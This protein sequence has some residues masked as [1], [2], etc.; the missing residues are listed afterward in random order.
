MKS[1]LYAPTPLPRL[2]YIADYVL[3][4]L[5][6]LEVIVTASEAEY[7]SFDGIRIN[8]SPTALV[9]REVHI[10]PQ[11]LLSETGV[12]EQPLG[13]FFTHGSPAIMGVLPGYDLPFD[14]LAA[15]FFVLTRYEEYLPYAPDDHGRFPAHQAW[16]WRSGCLAQPIVWQWA[17]ALAQA[18]QQ[19][20]PA[21]T[22]RPPGYGWLPTYDV[23]IPWA[24]LHRGLRGWARA[25]LDL[26]QGN[27]TQVRQRLAVHLG[28]AADPYYTF[29]ALE[30][31]HRDTHTRPRI[32]WLLADASRQDVNPPHQLPAYR[33][34]VQA[35]SAWS[36]FGI[37]PGYYAYLDAA[38][39]R[40]HKGRLEA[41]LDAPVT[42]SRQHFLRMHLPTT[43]RALLDAGIRHDYTMGFAEAAGYRAGATEPFRWYDLAT[44]QLTD[45]WVHPF[46]AMDVTLQQYMALPPA[47]AADQ[48]ATFQTYCR[49]QGLAFSTLW[50][51]SSF[52]DTHG[53]AGWWP[54]YRG[55][56]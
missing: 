11:G 33:Q 8:Y 2:A 9:E 34:L 42:H 37:H 13:T 43:Y 44:E 32:F 21:W 46:V 4:T 38:A 41:I 51:N 56:F 22:H 55:L 47:D 35:A 7:R 23:D 24:Y 1:T 6:G 25:G 12:R 10:C 53:W 54:V 40:Q 49:Q 52:S 19:H 15:S 16:A 39:I 45:L 17:L 3:G 18:I 14:P 29:A 28:R 36:D 50:H 26:L 20:Y 30:Q 31:L 48:L 5:L 27:V